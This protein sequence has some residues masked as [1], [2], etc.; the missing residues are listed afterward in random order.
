M[1]LSNQ[2]RRTAS[3][4]TSPSRPSLRQAAEDIARYK[5]AGKRSHDRSVGQLRG[6]IDTLCEV[7]GRDSEAITADDV[8]FDHLQ[9]CVRLWSARDKLANTTINV[10]LS[11]LSALGVDCAGCWRSNDIGLKWWLRPDKAEQLTRWLRDPGNPPFQN[12]LI[13]ADYI[14]WV[15]H[16]GMRVEETLR[17]VRSE[18]YVSLTRDPGTGEVTGNA[19]E[20]TVP[21]TKTSGAQATIAI[22][23]APALLLERRLATLPEGDD[24]RIFPISYFALKEGWQHCRAFLG[25]S[26]NKLATL[27]AIRRTAARHLTV[28]GMPLPVLKDMLRHSS[29]RT[30]EGYLRLTGGFRPE[31]QRK[32]LK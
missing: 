10:R 29:T 2:R 17:L 1:S 28:N 26:D 8:T 25:A 21:G 16:V 31:E 7:L 18:V 6:A 13:L 23:L 20:I 4:T 3:A 27:K 5:W 11:T 32:W 9:S 30:T 12:A 19:S 14:D 22:A 24:Q 15:S